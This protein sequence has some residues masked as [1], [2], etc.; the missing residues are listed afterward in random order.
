M[1]LNPGQRPGLYQPDVIVCRTGASGKAE[2]MAAFP[3]VGVAKK[4]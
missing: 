1:A 2:K 4:V 3:R